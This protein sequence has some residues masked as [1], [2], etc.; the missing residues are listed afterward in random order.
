MQET[1][2]IERSEPLKEEL[3]FFLNGILTGK[4]L[5]R[6]DEAARNALDMAIQI[7]QTIQ[8]NQKAFSKTAS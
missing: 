4:S 5:G 8:K 6:H 2:D 1:V 3:K 7:V